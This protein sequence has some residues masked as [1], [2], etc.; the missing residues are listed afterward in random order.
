MSSGEEETLFSGWATWADA[1]EEVKCQSAA[2]W[3]FSVQVCL[4]ACECRSD[5]E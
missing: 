3:I 2:L 4:C 5:S 1:K